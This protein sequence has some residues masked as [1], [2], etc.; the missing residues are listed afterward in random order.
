MQKRDLGNKQLLL[1]TIVIMLIAALTLFFIFYILLIDSFNLFV[2]DTPET[3]NVTEQHST[4]DEVLPTHGEETED[5][6]YPKEEL[7]ANIRSATQWIQSW[8]VNSTEAVNNRVFPLKN[9]ADF[10]ATLPLLQNT[11]THMPTNAP[12]TTT[13]QIEETIVQQEV[14]TPLQILTIMKDEVTQFTDSLLLSLPTTQ[15]EALQATCLQ[16][17]THINTVLESLQALSQKQKEQFT[18]LLTLEQKVA[19]LQQ[20]VQQLRTTIQQKALKNEQQLPRL[21]ERLFNLQN[22]LE[23]AQFLLKNARGEFDFFHLQAAIRYLPPS[24]PNELLSLLYKYTTHENWEQFVT[25]LHTN[26]IALASE[27]QA[28][29]K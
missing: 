3:K 7:S 9:Y 25:L 18:T 8:F 29:G 16:N 26:L 17:I 2:H 11:I 23:N 14:L 24:I 28:Y 1:R 27:I 15:R 21:A 6:L 12:A 10:I 13:Q 20:E 5:A 22:T 4:I 19:T